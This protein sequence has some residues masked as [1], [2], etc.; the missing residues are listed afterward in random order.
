VVADRVECLT[1][2]DPDD[3]DLRLAAP[4]FLYDIIQYKYILEAAV[5]RDEGFLT[6]T[7]LDSTLQPGGK[8]AVKKTA[9]YRG[10][11]DRA[12]VSCKVKIGVC[13]RNESGA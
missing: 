5:N 11:S 6:I 7:Q 13:F 9:D 8:D 1:D 2:I 3:V 4:R 12:P 10:D